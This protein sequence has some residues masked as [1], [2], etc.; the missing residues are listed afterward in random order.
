MFADA[1]R[2]S[3]KIGV[4]HIYPQVPQ[5]THGLRGTWS[6]RP[7]FTFEF[8]SKFQRKGKQNAFADNPS[9]AW[10]AEVVPG[11]SRVCGGGSG[12]PIWTFAH[13]CPVP[14]LAR[15]AA[16]GRVSEAC[17]GGPSRLLAPAAAAHP[18]PA[19]PPGPCRSQREKICARGRNDWRGVALL[20]CAGRSPPAPHPQSPG[21]RAPAALATGVHLLITTFPRS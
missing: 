18:S 3:P 5:A 21:V 19:P 16:C 12:R 10:P 1:L 20:L 15:R 11:W 8:Q 6:M 9:I 2:G 4:I 7:H 13:I 17:A 14:G